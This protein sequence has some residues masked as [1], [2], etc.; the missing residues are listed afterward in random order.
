MIYQIDRRYF[1]SETAE[2]LVCKLR[3]SSYTP[4]SSIKEYMHD[5]AD[6]AFKLYNVQISYENEQVFIDDCK[7]HGI[8]TEVNTH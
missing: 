6:R 4:T 8:I 7:K 1:A 3:N 2:E 5:F